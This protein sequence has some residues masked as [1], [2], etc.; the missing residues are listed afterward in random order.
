MKQDLPVGT[1][2]DNVLSYLHAGGI[3]FHSQP[4]PRGT[5]L[6]IHIGEEFFYLI[7]ERDVYVAL[8]FGTSD[9]LERIYVTRIDTCL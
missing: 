9:T 4:E 5:R 6:L 3:V 8:H 1:S 7:C 2:E